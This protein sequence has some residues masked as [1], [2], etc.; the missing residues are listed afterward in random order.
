MRGARFDKVFAEYVASQRANAEAARGAHEPG[1]VSMSNGV[2]RSSRKAAVPRGTSRCTR[3]SSRPTSIWPTC[4][5]TLPAREGRCRGD[6]D[7]RV[8]GKAPAKRRPAACAGLAEGCANARLPKALAF[9]GGARRRARIRPM[10]A[11]PMSMA[12]RCTTAARKKQGIDVLERALKRFPSNRELL[13]ALA[14]Y[15]RDSGDRRTPPTPMPN[16]SAALAPPGA[17]ES[18]ADPQ[19]Q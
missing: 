2:I 14:G 11:T 12:L 15:A 8:A 7:D 4:F 18:P 19:E 3:I 9:A 5:R 10:P 1:P 13:N 17:A 16:A 6:P